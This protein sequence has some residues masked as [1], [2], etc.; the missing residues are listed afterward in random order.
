[1]TIEV[2]RRWLGDVE[3]LTLR[4]GSL[5]AEVLT[6]GAHLVGLWAPDRIGRVDNVVVSLRHPGG[7]VDVD[8][9]RDPTR[10]PH[11]GGMVG[12]YANR[13]AGAGFELDGATHELVPNEGPNQLHGGPLGFDRRGW[14]WSTIDGDVD[15]A[16]V[17]LRLRSDD[18]DQGFPGRVD[19]QVAYRLT[20]S[21]ELHIDVEGVTDA[22]TVLNVTNHSYWNLAGTSSA[23]ADATIRSHR[24]S[25]AAD[26]VVAVDGTLLPTGELVPVGG[27]VFD[28]RVPVALGELLDR[29]ELRALGGLDH[30]YV[31]DGSDP[32]AE[33]VDPGSG[34]RVRISTD[35]PGVQVYTA[36]HGAGPL[37]RHAAVCLETQHLPDSPNQP[38]FP[39]AVLRP[40]A[41]YR[42][43]HVVHF[44]VVDR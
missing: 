4:A 37:P 38:G 6:H 23:C 1:M 16:G 14:A 3:L 2:D 26:R 34:R 29:S 33:L 40:G 22:P 18:G 11:L 17:V 36:N 8:A 9:Y 21:G 24:L 25:V 35:Q 43:T 39:S 10:N 41:T 12:R 30:C 5:R 19:V 13:I 31:L 20:A 15:G 32:A 44:D 7:E 28:L 27:S 42:H